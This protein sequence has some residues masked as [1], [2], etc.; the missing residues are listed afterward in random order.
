MEYFSNCKFQKCLYSRFCFGAYC[1]YLVF[2]WVLG[3]VPG[4]SPETQMEAFHLSI[5]MLL[6][7]KHP[8]DFLKEKIPIPREP[9]V[10]NVKLKTVL[11]PLE[12]P[13]RLATKLPN[14]KPW[15]QQERQFVRKR[16][17]PDK[18]PC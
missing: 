5:R 12:T 8:S 7:S 9:Q 15:T 17:L 6:P 10:F 18:W 14:P 11:V 16:T 3:F 4:N 1:V 13:N 2:V